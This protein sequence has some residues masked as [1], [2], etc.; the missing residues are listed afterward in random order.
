MSQNRAAVHPPLFM[1]CGIFGAAVAREGSMKG[2]TLIAL[3]AL[4]AQQQ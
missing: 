3:I 4:A 1:G 2:Q